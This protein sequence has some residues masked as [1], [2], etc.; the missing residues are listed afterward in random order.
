MI[1]GKSIGL[2]DYLVIIIQIGYHLSIVSDWV[3]AKYNIGILV[4]MLITYLYRF[5]V[6][7]INITVFSK[8]GLV[9]LF[10]IILLCDVFQSIFIDIGLFVGNVIFTLNCLLFAQYLYN[11]FNKL[12]MNEKY[13]LLHPYIVFGLYNVIVVIIAAILISTGLLNALSNPI[14]A[15]VMENNIRIQDLHYYFP[16]YLSVLIDGYRVLESIPILT[17]LSHEPHTLCFLIMPICFMSMQR[18]TKPLLRLLILFSFIAVMVISMSTT[19]I[20]VF[21]VMYA[22]EALWNLGV[23]KKYSNIIVLLLLIVLVG[24]YFADLIDNTQFLMSSKID[25]DTGSKAYSSNLLLY[26]VT[27]KA[28]L[29]AGNMGVGDFF[30]GA[31]NQIGLVTCVLDLLFYARLCLKVIRL[32]VSKNPE[33]H[34]VGLGCLYFTAH[35]LKVSFL[36]FGYPYLLFIVLIVDFLSGTHTK[37]VFK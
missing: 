21:S 27:P 6:L 14:S 4:F 2:V 22:I 10:F 11:I 28:L 33:L 36:V 29:G 37:K 7:P 5:R 19:A 15:G 31:T 18:V 23:S 25:T 24:K 35:A 26:V 13:K 3:V 12:S 17:G 20:I 16:G 32:V 8:N 1:R 9:S 30:Y 34:Y